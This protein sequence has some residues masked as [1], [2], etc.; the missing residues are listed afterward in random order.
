[1]QKWN[2]IKK[3]VAGIGSLSLL[4]AVFGALND[5]SLMELY[6][7]IHLGITLIGSVLLHKEA[8]QG[9]KL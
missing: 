6:F 8:K 9:S 1:M 5:Q 3:I 7:P 2:T 4:T